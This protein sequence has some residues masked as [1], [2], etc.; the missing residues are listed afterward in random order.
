MEGFFNTCEAGDTDTTIVVQRRKNLTRIRFENRTARELIKSLSC[1][2]NY[3]PV[4][5]IGAPH[6]SL[7][8]CSIDSPGSRSDCGLT[9]I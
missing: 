5:P 4:F 7:R 1:G 9:A 8:E 6:M 2:K 3:P